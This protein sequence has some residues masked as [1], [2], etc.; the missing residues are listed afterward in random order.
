VCV[1]GVAVLS[2]YLQLSRHPMTAPQST[3]LSPATNPFY[4]LYSAWRQ[5]HFYLGLLAFTAILAD[6]LPVTLA[7]VPFSLIESYETQLYCAWASIAVLGLMILVVA[8]SFLIKWPHMPVDP[9]TIAGALFYVSDSWMLGSLE[10]LSGAGKRD[11][12]HIVSGMG[13]RYNFGYKH[14]MSGREMVAIDLI[15]DDMEASRVMT[16]TDYR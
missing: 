5:R 13:A 4:G 12:D 15:A 14:G 1:L 3:L 10:G 7:H 9:R 2:P 11:R 8:G 16:H 6:F